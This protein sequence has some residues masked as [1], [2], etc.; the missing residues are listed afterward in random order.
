MSWES[1]NLWIDE[2]QKIII[3]LKEAL[4]RLIKA[5]ITQVTDEEKVITGKLRPF[6][7]RIKKDK[8]LDWTLN[9]EASS[10]EKESDPEPFA[11]PDIRFSRVDS[12]Y[13]DYHYDIECKLVRVERPNKKT[14]YCYHYVK[15]GVLRYQTCKYAQSFPPMGTMLGYVQ[16]GD[17]QLLLDLINQKI[18]YQQ[19]YFPDIKKIIL[20]GI[21]KNEGVSYL[22]QYLHRKFDSFILF[23]LWA[24]L[25]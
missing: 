13:D 14:D 18:I 22:T 12:N 8:M 11:H 24:D 4:I 17:L 2:E 25:R 20:K 10:F 6:L 7:K 19:K 23:H 3:C 16:Q 9:P 15:D 1:L 21:F 5:E